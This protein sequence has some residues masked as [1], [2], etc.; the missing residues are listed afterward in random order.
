MY[1]VPQALAKI[2]G[3]SIRRSEDRLLLA[4]F[5]NATQYEIVT[6]SP[7][8]ID[9][10]TT[11]YI[12][13]SCIDFRFVSLLNFF[14]S[15]TLEIGDNY[16]QTSLPGASLGAINPP[17][18]FE[19]WVTTWSQILAG[20]KQLHEVV[21]IIVMD[22]MNC[23]AY[24]AKYGPLTPDQEIQKHI[25]NMTNFQTTFSPLYTVRAFLSMTDGKINQ[26]VDGKLLPYA[27]V[28]D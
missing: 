23:G 10:H 2:L 28:T 18:G 3:D 15:V 13:L 14:T 9:R 22:H 6:S 19:D 27:T 12:V 8:L 21:E 11:K 7:E 20:A 4:K 25:E 16:D 24:T 17:T 26:V 1:I 5:L